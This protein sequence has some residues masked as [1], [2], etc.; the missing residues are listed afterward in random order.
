M[1]ADRPAILGGVPLRPDGPPGWPPPDPATDA[2][3]RALIETGEWGRYHGPHGEALRAALAETHGGCGVH[4]CAGGTAAVELALIGV[5]VTAGDEVILAGYDFRAN[6]ANVLALGAVPVAVDVRPDD[7]QIGP[8]AV[9]AALTAKTK[10]V[11]VSHL[12]G[13]AVDLPAVRALCDEAGVALIEDACQNP[14]ATVH[15]RPA[16]TW[17]DAGVL[18]FGGSKPLTAGRGGAVLVPS[19][20]AGARIAARVRRHVGRGN[21]LSPLSEMQAAVLLPQVRA[22]AE[23]TRIRAESAATL[24]GIAGLTPLAPAATAETTPGFYKMGFQYDPA[25]FDGLPRGLFCAA[26]RAE[27]VAFDP[28]FAALRSQFSGRRVRFVG[29]LPHADAA[30][31]RCVVLHH[32]V[33]LTGGADLAAIPAAVERVRAWAGEIARTVPLPNEADTLEL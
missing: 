24:R 8:D 32:P 6:A 9:R 21:D 15:G 18:S 11:L 27:G 13:G 26:L 25:A 31:A 12:H 2:A 3:L 28:G 5:G 14:G 7:W 20:P 10:A 17:G 29:D 19:N 22:L 30:G 1:N 16:G 33:L 23:R 4:L